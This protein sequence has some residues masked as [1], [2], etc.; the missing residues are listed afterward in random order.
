MNGTSQVLHSLW[1]SILKCWVCIRLSRPREL[2]AK[3]LHHLS[4]SELITRSLCYSSQF[5]MILVEV[6]PGRIG[7]RRM[8][9]LS[10][11]S[12]P[13][14]NHPQTQLWSMLL[15]LHWSLRASREP[16]SGSHRS[17]RSEHSRILS[18]IYRRKCI[19]Y[20]FHHYWLRIVG[21]ILM[22]LI[23]ELKQKC[24][25]R[26]IKCSWRSSRLVSGMLWN[27]RRSLASWWLDIPSVVAKLPVV[28]WSK[29]LVPP[30]PLHF[31]TFIYFYQIKS[32][33][34]ITFL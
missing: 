4:Q 27:I 28:H 30:P 19:F 1:C 23:L 20:I 7:I 6:H 8:T 12:L 32:I 17:Q 9:L 34:L 16:R 2:I 24:A 10:H 25:C 18:W 15:S 14:L 33:I 3:P 21:L 5:V 22:L 26:N 29:T 13:L 11:K 31:F